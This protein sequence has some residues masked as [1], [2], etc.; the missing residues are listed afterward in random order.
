VAAVGR[1]ALRV[2]PETLIESAR[3]ELRQRVLRR[4]PGGRELEGAALVAAAVQTSGQPEAE[5]TRALLE[6]PS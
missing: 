2:G 4:V 5:V 3:R 6:P 1:L